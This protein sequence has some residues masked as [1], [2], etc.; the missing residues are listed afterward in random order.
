MSIDGPAKWRGV[1]LFDGFVCQL[2]NALIG[3]CSPVSRSSSSSNDIP[4]FLPSVPRSFAS[5]LFS[6]CFG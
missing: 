1:C 2:R 6:S 3:S 5:S 4:F